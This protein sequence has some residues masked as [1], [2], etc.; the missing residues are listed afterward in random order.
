MTL[1]EK[2]E[3]IIINRIKYKKVNLVFTQVWC[4]WL[5]VVVQQRL[6]VW[7][8]KLFFNDGLKQKVLSDIFGR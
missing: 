5:R 3:S 1:C 8:A 4:M 6:G 7:Q 2:N